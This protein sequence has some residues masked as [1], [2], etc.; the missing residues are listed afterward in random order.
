MEAEAIS[1][2][3]DT[4]YWVGYAVF[5]AMFVSGAAIYWKISSALRSGSAGAG[6]SGGR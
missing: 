1:E 4:L 5:G 2:S 6:V 3:L